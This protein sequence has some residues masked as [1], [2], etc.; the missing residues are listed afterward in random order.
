L[1]RISG[2][3]LLAGLAVH[4]RVMH[5]AGTD[6]LTYEAVAAR[7]RDPFW[8]AFNALFLVSAIYHGFMGLWGIAIEYVRAGRLLRATRSVI[9]GAA[10]GLT[11]VGL[12]ILTLG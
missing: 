7:L 10:G 9:T 4:F 3:I 6:S 1:H 5:F 8:I 11:I 12:Y 2:V